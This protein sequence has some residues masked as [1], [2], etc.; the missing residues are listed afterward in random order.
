MPKVPLFPV[1]VVGSWPRPNWLLDALKKRQNGKLSFEEFNEIADEAVLLALKYQEDAGVDIV[2]DGE[3]RRDNFYSFVV[4][5]L[6]GVKLMP[7]AELLDYVEDKRAFEAI[8]KSL[9]VPA[10]GI[11][12]PTAVGRITKKMPLAMDEYQFLREHT[13]KAIKIPLPGPYLLTRTMWVKGVSDQA[14]PTKEELAKDVIQ[15][16]REE[17]MALRDAGCEYVQLDEPVLTEVVFKGDTEKTRTFMC[18]AMAAKGDPVG[19]LQF[20]VRLMNKVVEGIEGI[21]I[22]MHVCRG[23]WSRQEEVLL[24]GGYE[25]LMPYMLAMQLHQLV[26]EFATPRA[27][28]L[29]VFAKCPN[30]RELGLGVVNPRSDEIESPSFVVSKVKEA[31]KYFDPQKIYLNPDCG[32]GTFAER[33]MNVPKVA[34]EKLKVMT[35]AA[36]ELRKMYGNG[37][38]DG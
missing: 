31:L 15:L 22:G 23:N 35:K 14:Y 10:Y 2:S 20:A 30:V 34:F 28:E 36:E 5:K 26:L 1:T 37:G 8:L 24:K 12:T 7:V 4:E 16:L 9:D 27:G 33:P 3:Q 13:T 32:F 25:P 17:I 11:K 19:E 38:E 6:D 18:A 29:E 21:N